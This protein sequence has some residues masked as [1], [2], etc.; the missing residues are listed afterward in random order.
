M[1]I[2]NVDEGATAWDSGGTLI[3]AGCEQ[4]NLS[5]IPVRKLEQGSC[6]PGQGFAAQLDS[7]PSWCFC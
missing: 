1:G 3:K 6:F 4:P 5:Q 7:F 2:M